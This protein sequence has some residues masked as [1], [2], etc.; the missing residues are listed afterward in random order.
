MNILGISAFYHDSA[1][2]L[3][4]DGEVLFAAQE[5]RFTRK[6][7]DRSF[8]VHAIE[9]AVLQ[10]G[11]DVKNIDYVAYYDKPVLT[12][13]RLLQTYLEYPFQSYGSFKRAIP[14]WIKQ[15]LKMPKV[16]EESIPSD[17]FQDIAHVFVYLSAQ[18]RVRHSS[19]SFP[20]VLRS[21]RSARETRL[22]A[23]ASSMPQAAATSLKL[24]SPQ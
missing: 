19:A 22:R 20:S 2:C 14:L 3:V 11:I 4:Q 15:K 8:P 12:F 18:L 17:P 1:A 13:S 24:S 7:H 21:A 9:Q 5:E 16:I 6:K 10:T 23:A